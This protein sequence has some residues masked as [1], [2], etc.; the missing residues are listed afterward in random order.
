ML[1]WYDRL[2][3]LPHHQCLDQ[4]RPPQWWWPSPQGRGLRQ[5][6]P[7]RRK[8]TVGAAG[9]FDT[10]EP[11]D[12]GWGR[13]PGCGWSPRLDV[14][15]QQ[16]NGNGGRLYGGGVHVMQLLNSLNS[17]SVSSLASTVL[18][19]FWVSSIFFN[20]ILEYLLTDCTCSSLILPKYSYM[21]SS[22]MSKFRFWA[23]FQAEISSRVFKFIIF[24]SN[25]NPCFFGPHL[26]EKSFNSM[27]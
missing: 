10:P 3:I 18:R 13:A 11:R 17:S 4:W 16:G 14:A 7:P 22:S 9:W 21:F 24:D 8:W 26:W 20:L 5:R 27:Q 1:K 12:R 19:R 2:W 23:I 15:A 6:E 25:T